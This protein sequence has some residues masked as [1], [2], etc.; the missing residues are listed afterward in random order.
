VLGTCK[1]SIAKK[2]GV[3]KLWHR[4]MTDEMFFVPKRATVSR[5]AEED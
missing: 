4:E 2:D 5:L 3:Y 1:D